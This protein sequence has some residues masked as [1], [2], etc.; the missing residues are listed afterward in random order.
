MF[1]E[2][3]GYGSLSCRV[4]VKHLLR[5]F[6]ATELN[7][8]TSLQVSLSR[9]W[10][11]TEHKLVRVEALFAYSHISALFSYLTFLFLF[12][13]LIRS[14]MTRFQFLLII[15]KYCWK[16]I[17]NDKTFFFPLRKWFRCKNKLWYETFIKL[18]SM[19]STWEY[20]CYTT[21]EWNFYQRICSS[22]HILHLNAIYEWM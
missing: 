7:E 11:T 19:S 2:A 13:L 12:V 17:W 3:G 4:Q 5:C 20:K 9:S 21:H 18:W 8:D 16:S 14:Q 22:R 15:F 1:W 10:F 6:K